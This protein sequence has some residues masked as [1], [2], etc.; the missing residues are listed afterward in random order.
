MEVVEVVGI[1]LLH[2]FTLVNNISVSVYFCFFAVGK[3]ALAA[4]VSSY[5]IVFFQLIF[6]YST[7]KC[8]K[9]MYL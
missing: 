3:P 4:A 8:R 5:D 6:K 7:T 9:I 2:I 1:W